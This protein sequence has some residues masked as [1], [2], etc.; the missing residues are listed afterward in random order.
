MTIDQFVWIE[1][2]NFDIE[3]IDTGE[4]LEQYCLAFHNRLT[5][6]RADVAQAHHTPYRW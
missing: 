4:L 2:V 1:L 5:R 3:D 6:Q